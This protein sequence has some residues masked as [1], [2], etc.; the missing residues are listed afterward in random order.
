MMKDYIS[1]VYVYSLL[2]GLAYT[3]YLYLRTSKEV[4]WIWTSLFWIYGIPLFFL[5][6]FSKLK[7]K[8]STEIFI[9]YFST[10]TLIIAA[11]CLIIAALYRIIK[12]IKDIRAIPKPRHLMPK[13]L[14]IELLIIAI[15][16]GI[17]PIL[18]YKN[19]AWAFIAFG[20]IFVT[21]VIIGIF[22]N[23]IIKR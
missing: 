19:F 14:C 1:L 12:T 3:V 11:L 9:L 15:L 6:L 20:A 17:P 18:A 16:F 7:P 5:K 22:L 8:N 2:V 23:H 10:V 13:S 21:I 4:W